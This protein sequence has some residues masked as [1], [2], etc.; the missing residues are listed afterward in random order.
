MKKKSLQRLRRFLFLWL[1]SFQVLPGLLLLL[2]CHGDL[3][4][5]DPHKSLLLQ[6]ADGPVQRLY[7]NPGLLVDLL[8]GAFYNA[9][10]GFLYVLKDVGQ[11]KMLR[12][13]EQTVATV[14]GG[15]VQLVGHLLGYKP[16]EVDVLCDP[17]LEIFSGE[18]E[19]RAL[20]GSLKCD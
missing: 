20:R 9:G 6:L 2:L 17:V 18:K 5:G 13:V 15:T 4:F 12:R 10:M 1:F 14:V 16:E 7:R 8:P 19:D 3:P 11:E